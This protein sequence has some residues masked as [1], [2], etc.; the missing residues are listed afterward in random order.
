MLDGA[1]PP[2]A[3]FAANN[4]L[5]F[6]TLH[7]ARELGIRVPDDLALVTFDDMEIAADEP[8]LTCVD[9]PAE[10]LG[11]KAT[12]L[13]LERLAGS[14]S[15]PLGP[16][17]AVARPV[18]AGPCLDP[19][20]PLG[21]GVTLGRT[22]PAGSRRLARAIPG[23]SDAWPARDGRRNL[24]ESRTGQLEGRGLQRLPTH[25]LAQNPTAIQRADFLL[26]LPTL[27]RLVRQA[28]SRS[29]P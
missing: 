28:S 2:P 29:A 25:G 19:P 15:P 7:A 27:G 8:F 21:Y 14:E 11:R 18:A 20:G 10:E 16:T 17:A 3:L 13:L 23:G 26:N 12:R 6:G 4:F 24:S 1:D 22:L 5:A 9:Q